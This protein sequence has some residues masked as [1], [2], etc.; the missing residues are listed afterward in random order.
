ML[1]K[2]VERI[3]QCFSPFVAGVLILVGGFVIL[4]GWHF[5]LE[6]VVSPFSAG[7]SRF[8]TGAMFMLLGLGLIA[9]AGDALWQRMVL[10]AAASTLF[11]FALATLYQYI[12]GQFLGIDEIFFID[13]MPPEQNRYPGR[14][15]PATSLCFVALSLALLIRNLFTARKSDI[16]YDELPHKKSFRISLAAYASLLM[17][18]LSTVSITVFVW[19]TGSSET[20]FG[21]LSSGQSFITSLMF[22]IACLGL[23]SSL[24]K[25][26][27]FV[28]R[29]YWLPQ[30]AFVAFLVLGLVIANNTH[31]NKE[32]YYQLEVNN[33]ITLIKKLVFST[34]DVAINNLN[35][36]SWYVGQPFNDAK[37]N[38]NEYLKGLVGIVLEKENNKLVQYGEPVLSALPNCH[39]SLYNLE[40]VDSRLLISVKATAENPADDLCIHGLFDQSLFLE[41]P[42]HQLGLKFT[43]RLNPTTTDSRELQLPAVS[44]AGKSFDIHLKPTPATEMMLRQDSRTFIIVLS[45][46]FGFIASVAIRMLLKS[47][48]H[49]DQMAAANTRLTELEERNRKVLEMAPEAVLLVDEDGTIVYSN[50]RSLEIFGYQPDTLKG[51]PLEALLPENLRQMH[52][53][54]RKRYTSNPVTREMGQNLMLEALHANGKTFPVDIVLSPIEFGSETVVMA[55]IRDISDKLAEKERTKR[56]LE[57]KE[58]L[59]KEVYHRVKNNMQVISSLLKMQS[60]ASQHEATRMSLNE[61]ALRIA[62]LALVHEKLYQSSDLSRASLR[63]YIES[64]TETLRQTY[65]GS[66]PLTIDIQ[67]AEGDF[68]PEVIIPIGL[69]LN[70]LISNTMKHAFSEDSARESASIKIG[71][72]PSDD[73]ESYTLSVRDNGCGI[74]DIEALDKSKSLGLKLIKSLT[75]Q[76]RGRM[77]IESSEEGSYFGIRIPASSLQPSASPMVASGISQK[78]SGEDHSSSRQS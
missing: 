3:N 5:H 67:A 74:D 73:S 9:F 60:R 46:C 34:L 68:E 21:R 30:S 43:T 50:R 11:I 71:F 63:S 62:A 31:D 42:W 35:T 45:V 36:L 40:W 52:Q 66:L 27:P 17:A 2:F 12:S 8:N 64:L 58:V 24:V 14:P 19:L 61:A 69:I 76:L 53:Q 4:L 28:A 16:A 33:H 10:F 39:N 44:V 38:D 13:W 1:L 47:K 59:L 29:F 77:T 37:A 6:M 57:E 23:L 48:D 55:I 18:T 70:E 72:L 25:N 41:H 75:S 32:R 78:Y 15:S 54:H 20:I 7:V 56:D 49:Y 26:P 65:I 51:Q 22:L